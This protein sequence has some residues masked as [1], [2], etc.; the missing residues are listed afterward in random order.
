MNINE[1]IND[2]SSGIYYAKDKL[3]CYV[4]KTSNNKRIR[5]SEFEYQLLKNHSLN[6]TRKERKHKRF[7]FVLM[8]IAL[9]V[10]LITFFIV[11]ASILYARGLS[12]DNYIRVRLMNQVIVTDG[13]YEVRL[14]LI[15]AIKRDFPG[16]RLNESED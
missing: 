14:A 3:L 15:D 5:C 7:N 2:F 12:I 8:I 10:A 9:L 13:S 16:I 4:D 11:D 1:V 6:I